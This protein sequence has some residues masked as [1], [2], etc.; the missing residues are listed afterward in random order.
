MRLSIAEALRKAIEDE[1]KIDSSVFHIGEDIGIPGGF[2]GG[3]RGEGTLSPTA[4]G[5]GGAHGDGSTEARTAPLPYHAAPGR[6]PAAVR[7]S[8][9][10][11]R[12]A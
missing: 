8:D 12:D 6:L 5:G 3:V 2:G 1:M 7:R 11:R 10:M 4:P 9:C